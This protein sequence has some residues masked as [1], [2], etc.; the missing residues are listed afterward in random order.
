MQAHKLVFSQEYSTL[1]EAREIERR[2]KKLKRKDYLQK[3]INEGLIRM[4]PGE[5][6]DAP[7]DKL[8]AVGVPTIDSI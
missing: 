1:R 4:R 3:I 6:P 8:S 7:N 2:L 5:S